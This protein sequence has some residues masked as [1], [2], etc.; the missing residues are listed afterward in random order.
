[1]SVQLSASQA[2]GGAIGQASAVRWDG[3][4]GDRCHVSPQNK[5]GE[6]K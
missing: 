3:V 5:Y 2:R 4:G 6:H 1:V